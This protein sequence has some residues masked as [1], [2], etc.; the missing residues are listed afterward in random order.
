MLV[1]SSM[2]T[3]Q[4]SAGLFLKI[5]HD[6]GEFLLDL[7]AREFED[8]LV[9]WVVASRRTQTESTE[10]PAESLVNANGGRFTLSGSGIANDVPQPFGFR[11]PQRKKNHPYRVLQRRG[12]QKLDDIVDVENQMNAFWFVG[13]YKGTDDELHLALTY[14]SL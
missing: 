10:M 13:I 7:N 3:S 4:Q 8:G 9:A 5:E 11:V 2:N 12:A 6:G 1:M 14:N